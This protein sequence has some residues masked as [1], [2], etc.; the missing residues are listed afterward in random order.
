MTS[1]CHSLDPGLYWDTFLDFAPPFSATFALR[2][3]AESADEALALDDPPLPTPEPTATI[4]L[5]ST[6]PLTIAESP[7]ILKSKI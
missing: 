1:S 7:K 6:R 4:A 2:E 5:D 3:E